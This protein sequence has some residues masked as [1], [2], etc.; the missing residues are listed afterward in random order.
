MARPS[1]ANKRK[2]GIRKFEPDLDYIRSGFCVSSA[3]A[4]FC[5]S[6]QGSG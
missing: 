5:S 4:I 6:G 3:A 1:S 2:N